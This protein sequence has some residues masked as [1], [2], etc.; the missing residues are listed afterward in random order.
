MIQTEIKQR[1]RIITEAI[2]LAEEKQVPQLISITDAIDQIDPFLFFD[3]AKNL[4][5][6]RVFWSS[7]AD[8]FYL[9]G[10]GEAYLFVLYAMETCN[11][12]CNNI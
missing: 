8:D 2:A 4:D 1:D 5:G 10:A 6:E 11:L 9:V 12:K 7:T 3:Q